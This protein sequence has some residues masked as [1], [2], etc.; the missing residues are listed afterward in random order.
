MI[1]NKNNDFK[2]SLTRFPD[3]S[4]MGSIMCGSLQEITF[5]WRTINITFH[6]DLPDPIIRFKDLFWS[7]SNFL[8]AWRP[9]TF[10]CWCSLSVW[11]FDSR[12]S[13]NIGGISCYTTEVYIFFRWFLAKSCLFV[14]IIA[15][16]N[17]I[18]FEYRDIIANKLFYVNNVCIMN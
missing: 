14:T 15:R 13:E 5:D 17:I 9:H 2:W 7:D 10:V 1:K 11:S 16:L 18:V 12:P 8:V 4:P 6:P 3:K